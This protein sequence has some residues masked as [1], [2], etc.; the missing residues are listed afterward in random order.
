MQAGSSM[1]PATVLWEGARHLVS[2]QPYSELPPPTQQQAG[3]PFE[4][5]YNNSY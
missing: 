2:A 1:T 4:R 3:H 5:Q